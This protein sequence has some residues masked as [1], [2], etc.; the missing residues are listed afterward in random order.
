MYSQRSLSKKSDQVLPC[1]VFCRRCG[2]L[3]QGQT[4]PNQQYVFFSECK[5]VLCDL[6]SLQATKN[7]AETICPQCQK[8]SFRICPVDENEDPS[9]YACPIKKLKDHVFEFEVQCT[10]RQ[11]YLTYLRRTVE[12]WRKKVAKSQRMEQYWLRKLKYI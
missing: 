10:L 11:E 12:R 1:A 3:A 4:L 8:A 6:C 5:H 2:S 9:K 7:G